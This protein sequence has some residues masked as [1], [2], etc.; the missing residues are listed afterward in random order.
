MA[1]NLPIYS[2]KDVNITL[3][4]PLIAPITLAGVNALGLGRVTVRM[5]TNRTS[6]QIGMDGSP[7]VSAIPGEN[8]EIELQVW[9]TSTTHQLL[10]NWY[11]ALKAAQDNGDVT[12]WASTTILVQCIVDGSQHYATGVGPQKVPDKTYAEQQQLLTWVFV[13]A[14][15]R[16]N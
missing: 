14:D 5:S 12:N 4:N 2:G 13:C 7:A 10:V 1:L 6:V 3:S 16:H 15:I 8:G 11:N 9:Q